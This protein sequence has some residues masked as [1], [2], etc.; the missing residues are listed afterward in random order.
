MFFYIILSILY[1]IFAFSIP[2]GGIGRI[3]FISGQEF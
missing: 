1:K 2:G 3:L